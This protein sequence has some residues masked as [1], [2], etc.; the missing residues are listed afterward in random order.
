M[1]TISC[2]WCPSAADG[3]VFGSDTHPEWTSPFRPLRRADPRTVWRNTSARWR[4][5]CG[6]PS[7]SADACRAGFPGGNLRKKKRKISVVD[8]DPYVFGP[9]GSGPVNQRCGSGS[10]YHQAK[11]VR[12]ILIPRKNLFFVGLLKAKNENNRWSGSVPI[13][14]GWRSELF[15]RIRMLNT[16]LT[17]HW[18][19]QNSF[20]FSDK[21]NAYSRWTLNVNVRNYQRCLCFGLHQKP[22]PSRKTLTLRKL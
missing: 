3:G 16:A 15:G 13:C 11:I 2:S 14:H 10:F 12:K 22:N 7:W 18:R 6:P 20:E 21:F 17:T 1:V 9:P 5:C 4:R 19:K 8:P